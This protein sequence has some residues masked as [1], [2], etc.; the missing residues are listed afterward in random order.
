MR[1]LADNAAMVPERFLSHCIYFWALR[2]GARPWA[3][4]TR[5]LRILTCLSVED[6]VLTA[7]A[8]DLN[9]PRLARLENRHLD[10][11]DAVLEPAVHMFQIEAGRQSPRGIELAI[12]QLR[13]A[14]F[15]KPLGGLSLA[16]DDKLI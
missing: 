7:T 13:D 16:I 12:G 8:L 10:F 15:V 11:Q 14:V 3:P 9:L 6:F 1:D 4:R 2:R 5:Y